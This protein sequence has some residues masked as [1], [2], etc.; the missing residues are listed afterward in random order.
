MCS[1]GDL[2]DSRWGVG[3]CQY[4]GGG[5]RGLNLYAGSGWRLWGVG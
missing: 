5:R 2:G 3:V 4:L 1:G